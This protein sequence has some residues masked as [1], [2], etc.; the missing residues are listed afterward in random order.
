[1]LDVLV[2]GKESFK[3]EVPFK[4][5]ETGKKG[6]K[7]PLIVYLHGY[8]QNMKGFEK[9]IS[10]F[11]QIEAYHMLIEAPYPIFNADKGK[12]VSDWGRSW[13]L[14]DGKSGQFLKSLEVSSEFIQQMID[15]HLPLLQVDRICIF[16]YSMGG[17]LAGYFALT[18]WKHIHE[19]IVAGCRIKTEIL[20][21]DWNNISHMNILALHGEKDMKVK[22]RP[23]KEEIE[24]LQKH[25][26]SATFKTINEKHVLNKEFVDEAKN[27]LI[28]VG[29]KELNNN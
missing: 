5:S 6:V 29:Y 26:V 27:W 10:G 2:S 28:S 21:D 16:G 8:N 24:K 23:Q 11:Y 13:Y 19:L 17:Y 7:K 9:I 22:P 12:S 3:I 15:R 20:N 25:G 14:Y 1:M 4:I 18:R